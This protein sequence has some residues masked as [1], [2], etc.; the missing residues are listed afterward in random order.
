MI[1]NVQ[2]I[3]DN[4]LDLPPQIINQYD[5][6]NLRKYLNGQKQMF[7]QDILN[8]NSGIVDLIFNLFTCLV[9]LTLMISN[10]LDNSSQLAKA[11][12]KQAKNLF[13]KEI[14]SFLSYYSTSNSENVIE[15]FPLFTINPVKNNELMRYNEDI[16]KDNERVRREIRNKSLIDRIKLKMRT[17][18][19]N[20][21][22]SMNKD[23]RSARPSPIKF[24]RSPIYTPKT[25]ESNQA[26]KEM[27]KTLSS[28][29]SIRNS[30]LYKIGDCSLITEWKNNTNEKDQSKKNLKPTVYTRNLITKYQKVIDSYDHVLT[31]TEHNKSKLSKK[32]INNS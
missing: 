30:L 9:D 5:Y 25:T 18:R 24:N 15:Q 23:K 31:T 14:A 27:R 4:Q 13:H 1:E 29:S 6:L 19:L 8:Y 10:N 16:A 26:K 7:K 11:Q 2:S 17:I 12:I 32:N 20:S 3:E 21:I 22:D 28:S